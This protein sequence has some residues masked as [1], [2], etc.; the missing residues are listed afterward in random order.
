MFQACTIFLQT[1]INF[2]MVLNQGQ[3]ENMRKEKLIQELTDISSIFVNYINTKLSCPLACNELNVM[4]SWQSIYKFHSELQQCKRFNSHLLTKVTQLRRNAVTNLQYNKREAIES[5]LVHAD[6][7]RCFDR[8]HLQ[9][10]A[11]NRSKCY[12]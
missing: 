3:C 8:K 7:T 5:N 4:N 12:S 1:S 2:N 11:T 9:G 6:I 10:I